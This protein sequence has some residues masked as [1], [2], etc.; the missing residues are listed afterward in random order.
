[1]RL[2]PTEGVQEVAFIH[3]VAFANSQDEDKPPV[4]AL[5]NRSNHPVMVRLPVSAGSA[6]A[7]LLR[8]VAYSHEDEPQY[9][10]GSM[11]LWK[12]HGHFE[13][14]WNEGPLSP[15]VITT[16]LPEGEEWAVVEV[17]PIS[18]NIIDVLMKCDDD[19][20]STS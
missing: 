13:H 15:A 14:P 18:L 19:V 7:R 1:M 9:D 20:A 5:I 11:P 17:G 6:C 2:A 12:L 8:T 3:A 4:Y 10:G 16:P